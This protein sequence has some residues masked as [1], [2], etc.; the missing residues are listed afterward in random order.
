MVR[1]ILTELPVIFLAFRHN[2][3]APLVLI[4]GRPARVR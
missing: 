1:G 2:C 3:G 4:L